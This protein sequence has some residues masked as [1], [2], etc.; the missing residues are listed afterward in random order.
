MHIFPH[1][2]S[3][4]RLTKNGPTYTSISTIDAT[5]SCLFSPKGAFA[6]GGPFGPYE[7]L[8]DMV[9]VEPTADIQQGDVLVDNDSSEAWIVVEPPRRYKN[10]ITWVNSHWEAMIKTYNGPLV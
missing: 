3:Q 10:P 4:K 8:D 6:I 2:A 5:V 7:Q 9:F 1:S